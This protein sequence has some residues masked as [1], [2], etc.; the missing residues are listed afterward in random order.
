MIKFTTII[1]YIVSVIAITFGGV[2]LFKSDIMP[3]HYAF[4]ELNYNEL[5]NLNNKLIPLFL[6]LMKVSGATF[7][8]VGIAGII[9]T[10]ILYINKSKRAWWSLLLMFV[11]SL[12]PML[13]VTLNIANAIKDGEPNPPWYLT[14]IMLIM[15]LSALIMTYKYV[16]NKKT[17]Q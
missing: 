3:Y 5:V 10:R 17:E 7:I 16:F 15:L 2:Y 1:I 9:N 12:V 6:A 4:L 14:L 11:L 13:Y 8:S